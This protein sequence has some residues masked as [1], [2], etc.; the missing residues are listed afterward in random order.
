MV[1]LVLLEVFLVIV[2]AVAKP[3]LV[4]V[5]KKHPQE[6]Q[7]TIRATQTNRNKTQNKTKTKQKQCLAHNSD[8]RAWIWTRLGGN[9]SQESPGAFLN[10]SGT[11]ITIKNTQKK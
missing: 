1:V 5:L 11:K 7:T 8:T 6:H 4:P 9:C 10:S 2:E 3:L